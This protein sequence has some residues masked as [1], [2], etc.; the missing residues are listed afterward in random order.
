M[1]LD[2]ADEAAILMKGLGTALQD[3]GVIAMAYDHNT[4]QP[5]YPMRVIEGAPGHVK[6][7]AW[8][9]YESPTP[10]Y[11]VLDDL[12]YA[13]PDLLQFMTE[14]TT[15]RPSPGTLDFGVA[16]NFISSV[17]HGASGACKLDAAH[18]D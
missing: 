2:P 16:N 11:S 12:H 7:T 15:Y 10:N 6:A 14:C 3:R 9:C 5:A 1:F 8:H 17:Q 4:D 18:P 13:Y